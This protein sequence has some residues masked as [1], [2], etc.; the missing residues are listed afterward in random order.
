M[1]IF[2]D[3]QTKKKAELFNYTKAKH[4]NKVIDA[5]NYVHTTPF[6]LNRHLTNDSKFLLKPSFLNGS[7]SVFVIYSIKKRRN[8]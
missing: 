7:D 5:R 2:E 4:I 8:I 1:L 3:K 6:T